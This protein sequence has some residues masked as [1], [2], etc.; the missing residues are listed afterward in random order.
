MRLAGERAVAPLASF[1]I[2]R[3]Y[4]PGT[5]DEAASA[6]SRRL[7][8]SVMLPQIEPRERSRNDFTHGASL[9]TCRSLQSHWLGSSVRE[10]RHAGQKELLDVAG[11][12]HIAQAD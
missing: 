11:R 5:E 10:L 2:D 9:G 7:V 6:D 12:L 1:R 3:Q 8:V 4:G